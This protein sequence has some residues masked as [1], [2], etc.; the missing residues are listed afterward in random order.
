MEIADPVAMMDRMMGHGQ[1][2][3]LPGMTHS[4]MPAHGDM[5]T[6]HD[7]SMMESCRNSRRSGWRWSSS[8]S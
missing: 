2:H 4:G 8:P 3:N 1:G 6:M 5:S 7:M